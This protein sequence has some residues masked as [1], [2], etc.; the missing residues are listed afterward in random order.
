MEGVGRG[1]RWEWD[2]REREERIEKNRK[3]KDGMR[4]GESE[5]EGRE[6]LP[7]LRLDLQRVVSLVTNLTQTL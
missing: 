6:K 1:R 7:R 3:E 4:E 2:G 5:W